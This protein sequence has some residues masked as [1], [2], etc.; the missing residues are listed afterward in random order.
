VKRSA[1]QVLCTRFQRGVIS[2]SAPILVQ[3]SAASGPRFL[4]GTI[5]PATSTGISIRTLSTARVGRNK[6]RPAGIGVASSKSTEA[7]PP[8]RSVLFAV[9][10][11]YSGMILGVFQTEDAA[12][13]FMVAECYVQRLANR[14]S[15]AIGR[16]TRRLR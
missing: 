10:D 14:E 1:D 11:D 9:I 2:Q 7:P 6:P 3:I 5:M 4:P 15:Q 8:G 13:A 16:P 12:A